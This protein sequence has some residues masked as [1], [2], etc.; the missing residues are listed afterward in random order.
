MLRSVLN[1][2]STPLQ[3]QNEQKLSLSK[4]CNITHTYLKQGLKST[5]NTGRVFTEKHTFGRKEK[6]LT[7]KNQEDRQHYTGKKNYKALV[8]LIPK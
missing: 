1:S 7:K 5:G 2:M 4:N 8:I 3:T 6:A